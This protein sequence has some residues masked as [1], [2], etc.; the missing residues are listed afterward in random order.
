MGRLP[1]FFWK[2]GPGMLNCDLFDPGKD[3]LYSWID[4]YFSWLDSFV[5]LFFSSILLHS[6]SWFYLI[7][8]VVVWP[9]LFIR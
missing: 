7:S 5:K 4:S 3:I 8:F 6:S 9:I 1:T 2:F